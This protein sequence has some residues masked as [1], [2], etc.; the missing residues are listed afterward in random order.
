M[1]SGSARAD[2]AWPCPVARSN[3]GRSRLRAGRQGQRKRRVETDQQKYKDFSAEPKIVF[4]GFSIFL[5]RKN[6]QNHQNKITIHGDWVLSKAFAI[7][8]CGFRAVDLWE[9][10]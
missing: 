1:P 4:D 2:C 5:E 6:E 7:F 9:G 8:I 10:G 3:A